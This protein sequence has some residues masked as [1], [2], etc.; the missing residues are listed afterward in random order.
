MEKRCHSSPQQKNSKNS[1]VPVY[2]YL[3]YFNMSTSN[4][5]EESLLAK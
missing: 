5:T 1:E 2:I 4:R 3:D